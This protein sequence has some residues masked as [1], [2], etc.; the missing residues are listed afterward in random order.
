M[1]KQTIINLNLGKLGMSNYSGN[2]PKAPGSDKLS[3][4]ETY[5]QLKNFVKLKMTN[6]NYA[7]HL[8]QDRYSI[9]FMYPISPGCEYTSIYY[10]I[11]DTTN[12]RGSYIYTTHY[13][14]ENN[15]MYCTQYIQT[16]RRLIGMGAPPNLSLMHRTNGF[17]MCELV[18]NSLLIN[19]YSPKNN[20]DIIFQVLASLICLYSCDS[21]ID[22][23]NITAVVLNE[24]VNLT[25]KIGSV[26]FMLEDVMVIPIF[27]PAN[28]FKI[29]QKAG[30]PIT[31]LQNVYESTAINLKMLLSND[32]AVPY[33]KSQDIIECIFAYLLMEYK[34]ESNL[35]KFEPAVE[36]LRI[37]NKYVNRAC[38]LERY[39][40][41]NVFYDDQSREIYVQLNESLCYMPKFATIVN[42]T[43]TGLTQMI[44]VKESAMKM[45]PKH[46]TVRSFSFN[47]T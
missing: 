20:R 36:D 25:Y 34:E 31:T 15:E 43:T 7:L 8:L 27:R 13:I 23:L 14:T 22:N 12:D 2:S 28:N 24:P 3:T 47:C 45:K 41:G 11:M 10:D 4:F 39:Y 38:L 42:M 46:M 30:S 6:R 40:R 44:S 17:Y 32:L 16:L 1:D 35:C 19:K 26:E 18:T 5:D 21:Y 29:Y 9:L 33:I 37:S